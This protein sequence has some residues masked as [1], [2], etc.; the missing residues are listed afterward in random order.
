M[1]MHILRLA[2]AAGLGYLVGTVPSADVVT[3]IATG[4]SVNIREVG[5]GNPGA[6]NVAGVLGKKWGAVVMVADLLKGVVATRLGG[7]VAGDLGQHLAGPASVVGHCYPVWE[8]FDG[9]KGV[10][11][12]EGQVLGTFPVYFPIDVAV[13]FTTS[14]IPAFERQAFAATEVASAVWVA[15]AVLWWRKQWPNLWGPEPTLA[16][17][18]AAAASSAVIRRRFLDTQARVDAWRDE[19]TLGHPDAPADRAE[20]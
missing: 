12:S 14:R 15:S 8:D 10:A 2:G 4:G 13:A 9:G 16:L 1:S 20:A 18:L 6:A 7:R 3:R 11:T 17:P 19:G 5:T